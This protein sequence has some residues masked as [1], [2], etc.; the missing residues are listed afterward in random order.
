MTEEELKS[1]VANN[2]AKYRKAKGLTQV[3]LAEGINYSDKLISKWE[4][5]N[6]FPD[7]FTLKILADFL[8]IQVDDFY[9]TE[10]VKIKNKNRL[11]K[12]IL[13]LYYPMVLHG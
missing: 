11:K 3:E 12:N 2:I 6:G 5:G 9:K 8:G 13:Y 7:I 10:T 4:S 1:V